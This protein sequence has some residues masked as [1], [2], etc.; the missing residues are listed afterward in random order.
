VFGEP[1]KPIVLA[2]AGASAA[3]CVDGARREWLMLLNEAPTDKLFSLLAAVATRAPALNEL[4]DVTDLKPFFGVVAL[5]PWPLS[6]ELRQFSP[7]DGEPVSFGWVVPVLFDESRYVK[8][9][10]TAALV[11][12]WHATRPDLLS[13]K[14]Q[15]SVPKA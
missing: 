10:G 13:L 14:R 6:E 15:A 5:E 11:A 1:P 8:A 7:Q 12:H 2:T 9:N 4:I 3:P